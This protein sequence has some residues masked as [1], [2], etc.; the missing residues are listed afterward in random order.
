MGVSSSGTFCG[1]SDA[2]RTVLPRGRHAAP[3]HVVEAS[4]RTR[5]LEG[6]AAA[7]AEKGYAGA[8]VADVIARAGVSRKT[9]YEH[10]ANKEACFLAAYG[11][12]VE[13]LMDA[14]EDAVAGAEDD[15]VAAA[16]AG[17]RAYLATL[18]TRPD[19]ARAYLI[20][21]LAAGP[22][23]LEERGRVLERFAG[24]LRV[25]AERARRRVPG[26][27]EPAP[28]RFAACVAANDAI[29]SEHVRRHGTAGLDALAGPILD[30][31]LT[32]LLA[33]PATP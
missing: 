27:P 5:L 4:Q 10:F 2:P 20:E 33:P 21:V 26:L 19:F 15:P 25:V 12:G 23:A 24:Q 8:S 22:A 28:H 14:I 32:L 30:T 16:D 17:V 6:M 1:M 29:I 18:A 9:F 13:L 11:L 3:R 7:V 31:T